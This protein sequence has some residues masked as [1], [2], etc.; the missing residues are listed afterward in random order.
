[1]AIKVKKRLDVF[2]IPTDK[3]IQARLKELFWKEEPFLNDE[4]G[5]VDMVGSWNIN[6][7][8][9]YEAGMKWFRDIIF[10]KKYETLPKLFLHQY[11]VK[12]NSDEMRD[13]PVWELDDFFK[14]AED[15][16]NMIFNKKK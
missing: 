16:K 1:M 8:T 3:Q 5:K 10:K 13:I 11:E 6:A 2:S 7:V 15:M 4:T 9:P 14:G 12:P